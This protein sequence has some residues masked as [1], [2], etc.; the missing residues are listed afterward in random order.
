MERTRSCVAVEQ[1]NFYHQMRMGAI[2]RPPIVGLFFIRLIPPHRLCRFPGPRLTRVS[3]W[4]IPQRPEKI[5]HC[6]LLIGPTLSWR[7]GLAQSFLL[8]ELRSAE[9]RVGKEC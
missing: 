8:R 3:L 9:R 7:R 5:S 6:L 2:R 4:P 1:G